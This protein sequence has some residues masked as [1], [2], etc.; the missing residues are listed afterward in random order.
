MVIAPALEFPP[1]DAADVTVPAL[2]RER[3]I[4]LRGAHAGDIPFLRRLYASLRADELAP[5]P[6]P[7]AAK[8][9]FLDGQFT[10]QHRHYV[11]YY[12]D[13]DFLMIDQDGTSIGRYYVQRSAHDFLI[14]DVSLER[15]ARGQGIASALIGQ[16]Q[17]QAR[18]CGTGVQLHVQYG[19]AGARRLYERLGFV[20]VADEGAYQRMRWSPIALTGP[21]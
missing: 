1:Q 5:L 12:R 6:W 19:N 9:S 14:I 3:R 8:Q 13:A 2:L 7:Q 10:L 11:N 20:A 15:H 16:T 21:S 18:E 17:Q 4:C